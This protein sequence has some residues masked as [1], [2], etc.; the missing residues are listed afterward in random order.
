M[1][2]AGDRHS[3][4]R[5]AAEALWIKDKQ[6]AAEAVSKKEKERDAG[7]LKTQRLR[8]LRLAKEAAEKGAAAKHTAAPRSRTTRW[9]KT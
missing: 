8:A 4:A 2:E 7:A 5:R 3:K 1:S 6:R 9:G